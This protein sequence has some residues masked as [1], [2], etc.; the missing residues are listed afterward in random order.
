MRQIRHEQHGAVV[1]KHVAKVIDAAIDGRSHAAL[2]HQFLIFQAV[3][4]FNQNLINQAHRVI[5]RRVAFG[6]L[7]GDR[8]RRTLG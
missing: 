1:I 5:F 6:H 8:K 3:I 7:I 4:A 2:L